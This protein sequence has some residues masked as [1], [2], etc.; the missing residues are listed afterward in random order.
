M[1]EH[2]F[3]VGQ[4]LDFLADRRSG[5][6]LSGK[7]KVLKLVPSEGDN[8]QYRVRCQSENFERVVWENQLR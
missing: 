4:T 8:P 6:P 2:K 3:K 5:Q 1:S 7:C